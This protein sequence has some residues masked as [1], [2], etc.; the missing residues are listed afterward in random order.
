MPARAAEPGLA[1]SELTPQPIRFRP[2]RAALG[3]SQKP[4]ASPNAEWQAF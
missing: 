4:A 1:P 2:A 3:A